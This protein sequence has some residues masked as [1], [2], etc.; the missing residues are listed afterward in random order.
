M[1]SRVDHKTS[2]FRYGGHHK[3][4]ESELLLHHGGQRCVACE[5]RYPYVLEHHDIKAAQ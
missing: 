4:M 2:T 1:Q 3:R 5:R